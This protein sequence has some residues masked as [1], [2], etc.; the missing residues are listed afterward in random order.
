MRLYV[1]SRGQW[2]GTQAE[3]KKIAAVQVDVPVS[4]QELLEFLNRE[5]VCRSIATHGSPQQEQPKCWKIER[6]ADG[7]AHMAPAPQK[8]HAWQTIRECAERAPIKDLTVAMAV[9]MNRVDELA[10]RVAE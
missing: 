7:G 8:A 10:D 9:M 5:Q 2:V 1:N 3:A 4:K 6:D